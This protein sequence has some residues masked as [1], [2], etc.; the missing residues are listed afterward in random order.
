MLVPKFLFILL[1][2]GEGLLQSILLASE[3]NQIS[4]K[5]K[6]TLTSPYFYDTTINKFNVAVPEFCQ[7]VI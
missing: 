2:I 5:A 7:I 1:G 4:F 3:E 6:N